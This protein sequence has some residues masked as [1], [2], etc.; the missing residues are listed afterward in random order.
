MAHGLCGLKLFGISSHELTP[1]LLEVHGAQHGG[2]EGEGEGDYEGEGGYDDND[3]GDDEE[4]YK[5]GDDDGYED[6]DDD[7]EEEEEGG[8][9]VDATRVPTDR[10]LRALETALLLEV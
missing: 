9:D 4:D 7:E 5:E 6:D 1:R 8:Y 10:P 2:E 3:D